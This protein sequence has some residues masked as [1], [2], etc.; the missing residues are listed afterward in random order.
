MALFLQFE[1]A[2]AMLMPQ[3]TAFTI[4]YLDAFLGRCG[5]SGHNK[6]QILSELGTK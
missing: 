3:N 1:A 6:M 4:P 2:I 5:I